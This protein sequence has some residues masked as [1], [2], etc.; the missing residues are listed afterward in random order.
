[1][2]LIQTLG[3][4]VPSVPVCVSSALEHCE[5]EG[6]LEALLELHHTTAT[7]AHNLEAAALPHLGR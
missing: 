2:L 3:A 4:M 7:F 6:R 5:T 1:M